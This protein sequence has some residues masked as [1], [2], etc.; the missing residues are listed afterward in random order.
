MAFS[1]TE[2]GPGAMTT[3]GV[4]V[5]YGIATSVKLK[6]AAAPAVAVAQSSP[7]QLTCLFRFLPHMP[8]KVIVVVVYTVTWG[9]VTVSDGSSYSVVTIVFVVLETLCQVCSY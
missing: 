3:M 8:A 1:G 7:V 2:N 4:S 5:G 9:T 6:A